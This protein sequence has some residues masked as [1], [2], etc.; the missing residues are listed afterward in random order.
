MLSRRSTRRTPVS[1][2]SPKAMVAQGASAVQSPRSIPSF[3]TKT[4]SAF[5]AQTPSYARQ[6][7]SGHSLSAVH[8]RHDLVAESQ[9]GAS[10]P[11]CVA[12]RHATQ[13]PSGAHHGADAAGQLASP[14]H[15]ATQ[16]LPTQYGAA[17]S[18]HSADVV[19]VGSTQWPSM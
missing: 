12:S 16:V 10:P 6:I 15:S 7:P 17:G 11:Q 1:R 4:A 18:P 8:A 5:V 2:A 3:L 19:Q 9:I 14:S 13:A